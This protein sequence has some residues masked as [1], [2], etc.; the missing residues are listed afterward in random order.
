MSKLLPPA[1]RR[2]GPEV[3]AQVRRVASGLANDIVID[4]RP[5]AASAWTRSERP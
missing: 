5:F 3:C 2:I 4:E 1:R